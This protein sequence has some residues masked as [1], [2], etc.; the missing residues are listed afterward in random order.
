ML[1]EAKLNIKSNATSPDLLFPK[2]TG[3]T[4]LTQTLGAWLMCLWVTKGA[5]VDAVRGISAKRV[6]VIVYL[7]MTYMGGWV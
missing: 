3:R 4:N 5:A 1:S 2:Y 7:C 6:C